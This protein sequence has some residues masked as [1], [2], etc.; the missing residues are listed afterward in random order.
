MQPK[1]RIWIDG[2][3]DKIRVG[4]IKE[5]RYFIRNLHNQDL[6]KQIYDAI[7][8]RVLSIELDGCRL[9]VTYKTDEISPGFIDYLLEQRGIEFQREDNTKKEL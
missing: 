7:S 6:L 1:V 4:E 3:K 5:L 8:Y 2:R 9:L